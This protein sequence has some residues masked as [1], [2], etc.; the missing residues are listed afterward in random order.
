[1]RWRPWVMVGAVVL[2]VGVGFLVPAIPQNEAYHNFADQRTILGIP[3]CFDVISNFAFLIV[4]LW[5]LAVVFRSAEFVDPLERWPYAAFFV[6]VTLT[7]FGSSWYHL[8]PND[9]TLLWDRIPMTIGFL[10]LVSAL[11]AERVSVRTGLWLLA[12]LILLGV[13]SVIYWEITQ[14]EGRGDLRPYAIA[15][16]GSL[17]IVVV[18]ISLAP[19]RYTRTYD[20]GIS[21]GLYA[22]AKL[23]EFADRPVY[24]PLKIVSGHTLKHLAAALSAYWIVRMLQKRKP[25]AIFDRRAA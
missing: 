18:L 24:S 11:L 14:S 23:L 1:M 4:G 25:V 15:Q 16:F 13:A 6:G 3:H 12:P 17:L 8:N 22:L 20:L 19:A 7:S 9:S 5:G 2:T 10:G 21:L